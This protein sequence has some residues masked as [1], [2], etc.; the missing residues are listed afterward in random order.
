MFH[1]FPVE[2]SLLAATIL[3]CFACQSSEQSLA[4]FS[5]LSIVSSLIFPNLPMSSLSSLSAVPCYFR[6][7]LF[8]VNEELFFA[9]RSVDKKRP[10]LTH[11]SKLSGRPTSSSDTGRRNVRKRRANDQDCSAGLCCL[12]SIYFDFREHGMD[13]II[14]PSG[15]NMNFCD[16]E[17]SMQVETNDRDALIFQDRINHPKSPFLK[18]L[19]CCV[20]IR[21]SSVEIVEKRNGT[22]FDRILE[23]VKVV[24]CG[25]AI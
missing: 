5:S 6:N 9:S 16:G 2:P 17:C 19:S 1:W 10:V 13:N 4:S 20:P 23:N 18:R 11:H 15:F 21:W 25:C 3:T 14:R 22:E 24:E 12:K 7:Y 8:E